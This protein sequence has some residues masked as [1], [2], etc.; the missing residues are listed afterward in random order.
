MRAVTL[1]FWTGL[2]T[3]VVAG[4]CRKSAP[5][6]TAT[7]PASAAAARPV[8]PPADD[9][10]SQAEELEIDY[11]ATSDLYTKVQIMTDLTDTAPAS[12][13]EVL[14]RLFYFEEDA[15]LREEL[16]QTLMEVDGQTVA[17]RNILEEATHPE[18]PLSV[19]LTA[20]DLLD[21]LGS[22]AALPALQKLTADPNQQIRDAAHDA[23][24]DVM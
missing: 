1:L 7:A 6:S 14:G 12:A 2:A 23:I 15:E 18:I 22:K 3:A 11:L 13:V 24:D 10:E 19:R 5:N 17:K 20:I 9:G 4:G 8:I 21:E 16:L